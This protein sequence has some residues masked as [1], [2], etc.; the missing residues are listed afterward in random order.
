M[1]HFNDIVCQFEYCIAKLSKINSL[2]SMR[3]ALTKIKKYLSNT[4]HLN[5]VY[6]ITFSSET[7]RGQVTVPLRQEKKIQ[8][9]IFPPSINRP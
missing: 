1:H 3:L 8:F 7:T 6:Q 4:L 9:L 5:Y 2:Q